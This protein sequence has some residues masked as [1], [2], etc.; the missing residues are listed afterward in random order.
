M[1]TLPLLCPS[2]IAAWATTFVVCLRN[3]VASVMLLPPGV[4]TVGSYIF[5]QSEQGDIASAMAMAIVSTALRIVVLLLV[6]VTGFG[7]RTPAGATT[8]LSAILSS[9][10]CRPAAFWG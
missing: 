4:D 3:L 2:L 7:T 5:S 9:S 6:R 1:V 10:K 8:T